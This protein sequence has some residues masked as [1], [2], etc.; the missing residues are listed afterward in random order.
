[1]PSVNA[2]INTTVEIDVEVYCG[3]CGAGLCG[4]S[5][6]GK[7]TRRGY[8]FIQV[9]PCPHCLSDEFDRGKSSAPEGNT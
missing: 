6:A 9:N 8:P 7:T 3:R 1:M 2:E 5:T 4:E